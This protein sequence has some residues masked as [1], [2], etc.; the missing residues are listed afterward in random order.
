M[1][2]QL[3]HSSVSALVDWLAELRVWPLKLPEGS[4]RRGSNSNRFILAEQLNHATEIT[5][6][7]N[8]QNNLMMGRKRRRRWR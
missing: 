4:E 1:F 7:N 8:N 3:S 6:N 5:N 2:T